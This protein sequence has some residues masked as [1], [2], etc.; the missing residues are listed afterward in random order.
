MPL[1][2]DSNVWYNQIARVNFSY[3]FRFNFD[4]NFNQAK[5]IHC[6]KH[7]HP[8]RTEVGGKWESFG[9]DLQETR[10]QK[11]KLRKTNK[12]NSNSLR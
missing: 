4:L 8:F 1:K 6:T 12:H 2:R 7:L 11:S 3:K 5:S 9:E 10:Q